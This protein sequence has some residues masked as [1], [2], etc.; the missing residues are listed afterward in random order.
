[1]KFKTLTV[2]SSLYLLTACSTTGYVVQPEKETATLRVISTDS[3]NTPVWIDK[4]EGC[5]NH[6]FIQGGEIA[7][8]GAKANLLADRQAGRKLGMPLYRSEVHEKQQTELKVE[9]GVPIS[10]YFAG[11]WVDGTNTRID[12]YTYCVKEV[13][14]TPISGAFY[15]AEYFV[16]E[17]DG[18]DQC[19]IKLYDIVKE[20]GS[21]V[22]QEN[23][24]YKLTTEPCKN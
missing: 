9:A 6:N 10:F 14:F 19:T 12:G 2:L 22:K 8:L 3:A 1:M 11:V 23:K 7:V 21:F 13:G 17:I 24:D 20:N 4:T 15:E 18:K 16:D 5:I